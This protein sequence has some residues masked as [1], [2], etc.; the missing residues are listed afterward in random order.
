ML[1]GPLYVFSKLILFTSF[2]CAGSLLLHMFLSSCSAQAYRH[3]G[4]SC[5]ERGCQCVWASAVVARGLS[6]C[7]SQ[8]LGRRQQLWCSGV[9]CSTACRISLDQ[10]LNACF[11]RWQVDSLPRSHQG[12]PICMSYSEKCLFKFFAHFKFVPSIFLV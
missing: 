9:C 4:F 5:A 11:L 3:N 10:E 8:A 2:G 7:N 12:S 6:S 1:V